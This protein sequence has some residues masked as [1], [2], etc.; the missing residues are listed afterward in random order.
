MPAALVGVE[1]IEQN[2]LL[3]VVGACWIA[4]GGTDAAIFFVN[5]IVRGEIFLGAVAPIDAG[6]LVQI[7][8]KGFGQAVG[9]GLGHDRVVIVVIFLEVGGEFVAADAG[10]DGEGAEVILATAFGG[11]MKSASEKNSVWPLRSHCWRRK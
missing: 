9:Q 8:G 6:L 11:A 10:G 3:G 2:S 4:G 5:Q 1:Q 7:F